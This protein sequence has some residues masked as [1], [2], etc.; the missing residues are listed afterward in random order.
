MRII[1]GTLR[2]RTLTTSGFNGIRPTTD[3][4]RET[5]FNILNNYC[6]FEGAQVLDLCAG[7]GA[8]A[9]EAV[10]RGAAR[11]VLVEKH[12]GNAQLLRTSAQTLGVGD[13]I[14]ILCADCVKAIGILSTS[15]HPSTSDAF[16]PFSL[17]FC[18][19]PYA[20]RLINPVIQALA[21]S[22]LPAPE[23]LFIAEHDIRETV[24]LPTGWTKATERVFGETVVDFF[25]CQ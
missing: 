23:A 22:T 20:A 15:G 10:S 3:R 19:P 4:V 17:I 8:L 18:D 11:A 12:R 16:A 25:W 1:G 9:F 7:S 13:S 14:T 5:I 6:D 24:I 2:G 21:N